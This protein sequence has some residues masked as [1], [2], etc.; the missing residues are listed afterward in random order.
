M[1]GLQT[2]DFEQSNVEFVEFLG[3]GSFI[4]AENAGNSG[5]KVV[6]N[7]GSITEDI[8]KDGRKQFENG[9]PEDGEIQT[10]Y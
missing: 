10:R 3:H 9:L 5:G 8:S 7:F 2:T 1:R 6:L 4:Y